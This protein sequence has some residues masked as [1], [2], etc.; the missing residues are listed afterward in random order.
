MTNTRTSRGKSGSNRLVISTG[1]SDGVHSSTRQSRA[2]QHFK[3]ITTQPVD[4][5]NYT[6][7]LIACQ[8]R[9]FCLTV[10]DKAGFPRRARARFVSYTTR[11]AVHSL[12]IVFFRKS[13]PSHSV[14]RVSFIP[15]A[16][17]IRECGC[18]PV[19]TKAGSMPPKRG[20]AS[21]GRS[22]PVAASSSLPSLRSP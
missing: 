5:P 15:L 21:A 3:L 20:S 13:R 16:P 7:C 10:R 14:T 17:S 6:R 12:G 1:R 11:R 9:F 2:H 18:W 22:R 4:F 19:R 8:A